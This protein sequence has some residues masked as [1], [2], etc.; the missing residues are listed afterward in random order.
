MSRLVA[1]GDH[2]MGLRRSRPLGSWWFIPATLAGVVGGACRPAALAPSA[3]ELV[4]RSGDTGGAIAPAPSSL[5]A[6]APDPAQDGAGGSL[7]APAQPGA[8]ATERADRFAADLLARLEQRA[9]LAPLFSDGWTL[10]YYRHQRC[11]GTTEGAATGLS[12][13][14]V[15]QTITVSVHNDGKTWS[16]LQCKPTPPRRYDLAFSLQDELRGCDPLEIYAHDRAS[17]CVRFSCNAMDSFSACYRELDAALRIHTLQTVSED[18][19]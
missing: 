14:M 18:P 9:P 3:A 8:S 2:E 1:P 6:A 5:D 17:G 4:A 16:W 15:D 7:A 12:A 19:G 13:A 10:E 11:E